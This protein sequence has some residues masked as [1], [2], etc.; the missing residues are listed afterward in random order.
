MPEVKS[1]VSSNN[2]EVNIGQCRW[3][4]RA[5]TTTRSKQWPVGPL[6]FYQQFPDAN[7]SEK[8]SQQTAMFN[9]LTR[10]ENPQAYFSL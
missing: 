5:L 3:R 8:E 9:I 10:T 4:D 7:L 6:N 1:A 2:M